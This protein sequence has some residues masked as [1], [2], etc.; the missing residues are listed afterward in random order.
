MNK[1]KLPERYEIVTV[2]D[3]KQEKELG[4]HILDF[5]SESNALFLFTE[6]GTLQYTRDEVEELFELYTQDGVAINVFD[7][8]Y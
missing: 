2:Y 6:D 8:S 4:E 3:I 5:D 1:I 7:K